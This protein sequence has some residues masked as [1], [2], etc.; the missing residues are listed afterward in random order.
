M[1]VVLMLHHAEH[2]S[3]FQVQHEL[4]VT[5]V[6]LTSCLSLKEAKQETENY[7]FIRLP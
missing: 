7:L 3:P 6:L 1:G 5:P 2:L 4:P